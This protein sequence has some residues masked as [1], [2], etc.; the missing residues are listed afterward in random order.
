MP[1]TIPAEAGMK[2][3]A[4]ARRRTVPG[5]A[6]SSERVDRRSSWRRALNFAEATPKLIAGT[7]RKTVA[8]VASMR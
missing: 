6:P 7:M 2:G 5:F 1:A 8:K 3:S 4:T